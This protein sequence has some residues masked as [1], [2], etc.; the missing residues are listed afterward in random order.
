[1]PFPLSLLPTIPNSFESMKA[2]Q[3]LQFQNTFMKNALIR[4]LNR[5]HELASRV[6]PGSRECR[7][8]ADYVGVVCMLLDNHIEGDEFFLK[9]L[10]QETKA[11]YS[12]NKSGGTVQVA[13]KAIR[14]MAEGW[15]KDLKAYLST[16]LIDALVG[17]DKDINEALH[18]QSTKFKPESLPKGVSDDKVFELIG[19]NLAWIVTKVDMNMVLPYC[20]SHHDIKTS[21][22]WPTANPEAIQKELPKLVN[23]HAEMWK[24]APFDPLSRKAIK[25]PV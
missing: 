4:G 3:A 5:V 13:L 18:K 14:S 7:Q 21:S 10:A 15:K 20:M 24:L 17:M 1:M 16:R 11:P 25:A 22:H 9:R 8:F 2:S 6:K 23:A 19:E 12:V